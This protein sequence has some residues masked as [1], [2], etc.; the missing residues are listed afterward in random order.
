M[1]RPH[2]P[3]CERALRGCFC[4]W[5][6]TCNN[7]VPVLILQHPQERPRVKNTGLLLHLSL[8]HSELLVGEQWDQDTLAAQLGDTGESLLLYPD[9]GPQETHA[10]KPQ[11]THAANPES[12]PLPQRLIVID[13]TWRKSRKMLY[14]NPV[15]QRLPRLALTH[16]PESRYRIRRAQQPEQLSTLEASCYALARLEQGH[17]NYDPLLDAFDG[18]NDAQLNFIRAKRP[19]SAQRSTQ[20]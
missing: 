6:R 2:C 4:Q 10:L 14:L 13:A 8:A 7:Q 1:R 9:A 16:T 20:T 5:I 12:R 17:V 19:P 11:G 15:L 3:R 18:F